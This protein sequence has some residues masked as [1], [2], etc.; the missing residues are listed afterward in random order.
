[1][2]FKGNAKVTIHISLVLL[3]SGLAAYDYVGTGV[4]R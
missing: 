4:R 1:M 3:K 2:C